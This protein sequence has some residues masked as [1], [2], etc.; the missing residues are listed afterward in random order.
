MLEEGPTEFM[1]R[2][3]LYRR[4]KKRISNFRLAEHRFHQA[5]Y[6]YPKGSIFIDLGA[7]IGDVT[8]AARRHGMKVIAFEPDPVARAVLERRTKGDSNVTVVPKAI[9]GRARI[10]TFHQ[11]PDVDDLIKTQS[12]S[13]LLTHEH[14]GGSTF[15][16]EVMD[17]VEFIE[18]IEGRIAA[19]KMDIEG[20]EI[21]CLEAIL[22]AGCHRRV[23]FMFVETHER[24]S[25][26]LQEKTAV[27]RARIISEKI[28]N[29]DLNWV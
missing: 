3:Y 25:D 16:V 1:V 19:I 23:G 11:R 2:W 17:I 12:S 9:G 21:E 5:L 26:D 20:A 8:L 10:A 4:R 27:L 14:T 18:Q 22:N 6:R 13:L 7:N 24:F 15:D 28:E 29:I